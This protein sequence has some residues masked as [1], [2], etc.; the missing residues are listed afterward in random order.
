ML[1][2]EKRIRCEEVKSIVKN[3]LNF[4]NKNRIK[5]VDDL[6]KL[7]SEKQYIE[8][9]ENK[10]FISIT[11]Y[12]QGDFLYNMKNYEYSIQKNHNSAKNNRNNH[13]KNHICQMLLLSYN[14]FIDEKLYKTPLELEI[15]KNFMKIIVKC[16]YSIKDYKLRNVD[17]FSNKI[18][19]KELKK[20][21]MNALKKELD[22]LA[23]EEIY[24]F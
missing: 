10:D 7:V 21:N 19:S 3:V 18:Q 12:T 4:F 9:F 13:T 14:S 15:Q 23:L 11:K 24:A 1:I 2:N 20:A 22:K 17:F 6:E 8:E 5:S 16:Y